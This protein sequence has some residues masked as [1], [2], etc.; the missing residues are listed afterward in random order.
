MNLSDS[1]RENA[2]NNNKSKVNKEVCHNKD[3][4]EI[5]GVAQLKRFRKLNWFEIMSE[6]ECSADN[7]VKVDSLVSYY[8]AHPAMAL[9]DCCKFIRSEVAMVDLASAIG[10]NVWQFKEIAAL[11]ESE[12]RTEIAEELAAI[13]DF[14]ELYLM[15]SLPERYHSIM[16]R[17]IDMD[18]LVPEGEPRVS[19]LLRD[20][21]FLHSLK[22]ISKDKYNGLLRFGLNLSKKRWL[23]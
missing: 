20:L 19:G 6:A 23:R 9:R 21:T 18:L 7:E 12:R 5:E 8:L 3:A 13:A 17:L 15:E 22:L 11:Y 10:A 1:N 14:N 16:K 4:T 2:K